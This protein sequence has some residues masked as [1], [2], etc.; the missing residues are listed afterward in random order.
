LKK[1]NDAKSLKQSLKL[2]NQMQTISL[3]KT[4]KYSSCKNLKNLKLSCSAN[5][6]F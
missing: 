2:N 5:K 3:L 6:K 1:H 4:N